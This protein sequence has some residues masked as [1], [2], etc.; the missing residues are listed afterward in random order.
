MQSHSNK[1]TSRVS[2]RTGLRFPSISCNSIVPTAK[3]SA[4]GGPAVNSA[5]TGFAL[6]GW[7]GVRSGFERNFA[8]GQEMGA[9]LV[10]YKEGA[11]VVDLAGKSDQQVTEYTAETMQSVASAGKMMESVA[12]AILVSRGLV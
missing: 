2:A 10:I 1:S 8:E 5:V 7:E 3:L 12:M 9:Q 11:V 6:R 4:F